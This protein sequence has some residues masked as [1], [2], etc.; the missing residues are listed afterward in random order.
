MSITY[1]KNVS[2]ASEHIREIEKI[3]QTQDCDFSK[4]LRVI[5]DA[6]FSVIASEKYQQY[7]AKKEAQ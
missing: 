4:A 6:Y 2:F 1:S 3:M 5:L 7:Q